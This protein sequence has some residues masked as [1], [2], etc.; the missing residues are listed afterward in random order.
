VPESSTFCATSTLNAPP[1]PGVMSDAS[2]G[3]LSDVGRRY[4][5]TKRNRKRSDFDV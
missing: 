1:P 2:G 5:R 3:T 4:L